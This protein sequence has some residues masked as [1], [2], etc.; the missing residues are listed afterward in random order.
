MKITMSADGSQIIIDALDINEAL[1]II[2]GMRNGKVEEAV[3]HVDDALTAVRPLPPAQQQVYDY[4]ADNDHPD[5]INR[6]DLATAFDIGH[7]AMDQRLKQ[8]KKRG[9]VT[10]ASRGQ[11]R[12]S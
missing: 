11:W 3:A 9:L 5:G 6:V 4:L 1:E 7:A 2:R 12:I 8:L 10:Q